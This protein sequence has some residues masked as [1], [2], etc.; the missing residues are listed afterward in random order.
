ML[1]NVNFSQF[2]ALVKSLIVCRFICHRRRLFT[3]MAARLLAW[4]TS[5]KQSVRRRMHSHVVCATIRP[6]SGLREGISFQITATRINCPV[7][8]DR[9]DH[10]LANRLATAVG[11]IVDKCWVKF[12]VAYGISKCV[13]D[14]IC[15][16][17]YG[18][19]CEKWVRKIDSVS[20]GH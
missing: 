9:S 17:A 18:A 3:Y 6:S 19:R 15:F 11:S 5:L 13:L 4:K 10:V 12:W 14:V 8:V 7:A 2:I 1:T 20:Q 16:N